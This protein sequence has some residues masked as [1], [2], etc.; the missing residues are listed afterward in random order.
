MVEESDEKCLR[1][2]GVG[3]T[4]QGGEEARMGSIF[5]SIQCLELELEQGGRIATKLT[6][7]GTHRHRSES[8]RARR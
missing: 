8:S 2:R 1:D 3:K 4:K 7:V 6:L 5:R